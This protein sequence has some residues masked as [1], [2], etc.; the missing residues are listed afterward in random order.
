MMNGQLNIEMKYNENN[1]LTYFNDGIG[2]EVFLD[3]DK[4]GRLVF[5]H[6]V[7]NDVVIEKHFE[8]GRDNRIYEI[9]T[10]Y[11]DDGENTYQTFDKYSTNNHPLFEV[12]DHKTGDCDDIEYTYYENG[13]IKTKTCDSDENKN[14]YTTDYYYDDNNRLIRKYTLSRYSKKHGVWVDSCEVQYVYNKNGVR[15]ISK[16]I[17]NEK[18]LY[19][20]ICFDHYERE[21]E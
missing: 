13:N 9:V 18:V 11:E 15:H 20:T 7:N 21:E 19:N 2:Y 17:K 16:I 8:Y 5:Q 4:K 6:I 1:K 14:S 12:I 3:Y 10:V